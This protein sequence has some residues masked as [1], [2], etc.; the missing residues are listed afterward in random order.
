MK[1]TILTT[2]LLF[3]ATGTISQTLRDI[4]SNVFGDERRPFYQ[5]ALLS[6]TRTALLFPEFP[7]W[8]VVA[9]AILYLAEAYHCSTRKYLSHAVDDVNA[10]LELL[11]EA[12]PVI[13]WKVRS[14]HFGNPVAKTLSHLLRQQINTTTQGTLSTPSMLRWKRV[15]HT[16]KGYYQ[17]VSCEDQTI[18]GVWKRATILQQY[19]RMPLT[20]IIL[21]KTLLLHDS[22][23]RE[24]YFAQQRAFLKTE[25]SDDFAEFTT[26]VQVPGYQTCVLAVPPGVR[27]LCSQS[28]FWFFTLAGLT[29]P[30][31]RWLSAKCNEVRVRVVKETSADK[32][33][34]GWFAGS[35]KTQ[36]ESPFQAMMQKLNTT[37]EE[38]N[39]TSDLEVLAPEEAA[40]LALEDCAAKSDLNPAD[41]VVQVQ[42]VIE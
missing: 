25:H 35:P 30:Y 31:R 16:A 32:A 22:K 41:K 18:A 28:S 23:A 38:N 2:L 39:E 9:T 26:S 42:T 34:V 33:S 20:K 24:D 6:F 4:L 11:R 29:V 37:P 15:T 36:T 5:S 1:A 8:F 27:L 19:R 12:S 21:T 13:E 3:A 17:Y 10:Y 7:R 40:I 14:F